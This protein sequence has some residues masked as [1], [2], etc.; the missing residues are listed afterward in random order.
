MISPL[1]QWLI[2]PVVGA[3]IGYVTND[4]AIKM[5]FRPLAEKR[6]F[7]LRI[8]FTPGILPRQ[9]KKLA[10]NIGRM[11]SRELLTEA[12]VKDRLRSDDFRTLV[13]TSISGYTERLL[14][15]PVSRIVRSASDAEGSDLARVLE[16]VA[17]RFIDSQAF[18]AII[19]SLV[20]QLFSYLDSHTA[21]DLF[22]AYR[23]R[24][25]ESCE[26]F[27]LRLIR[28]AFT[29]ANEQRLGD[30]LERAAR[31]YLADGKTIADAMPEG[32]ADLSARLAEFAYPVIVGAAVEY[33]NAPAIR[34][35]LEIRGKLFLKD[36][37]AELNAFQRF[38]VSAA[39]Y[40][41]TLNDRMPAIVDDLIVQIEDFAEEPANRELFVSAIRRAAETF[42]SLTV[43]EA[44]RRFGI[45]PLR[46]A[47][48]WA[49]RI[50]T[51][52]S[53]LLRED[54]PSSADPGSISSAV[55]RAVTAPLA[56]LLRSR[57][58]LD[59]DTARRRL[60]DALVSRF[61]S[62][63]PSLVRP[64]AA[65]ILAEHGD[66]SLSSFLSID[67]GEKDRIDEYL[68]E[69]TLS[70]MD[71]RISAVLAG[72]DIEKIV[73]DRIDSLDME[74]VERIVLDVL[75]DQ[76]KWINVFGALLG[77]LL[78]AFQASLSLILS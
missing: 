21:K 44:S 31:Q 13:R 77:A 75:A 32:H 76:L 7:G 25:G 38:F 73:A 62:N 59:I 78:G 16:S 42:S 64:L 15:E 65:G 67:S 26:A 34:A 71:E 57:L 43:E 3:V 41:K 74:D 61:R 72:L 18:S 29:P 51:G 45:D 11:V 49:S 55:M 36:A 23:G 35:E 28:G 53:G 40:D 66:K 20:D 8:P 6:L 27:I 5:L 54:S 39:Q 9:R 70:L 4:I 52:F 14:E 48:S 37:M 22:E 19:G 60:A 58:G 10:A 63:G 68:A 56:E 1:V 17:R 46:A 50:F 2:P 30:A 24:D 47:R 69:K 33:L 12:I